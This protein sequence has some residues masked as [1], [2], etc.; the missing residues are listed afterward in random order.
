MLKAEQLALIQ[1][2]NKQ[3][4]NIRNT[5]LTYFR[6][7]FLS[8]GVVTGG[9]ICGFSS[10]VLSQI[11][12]KTVDVSEG[13]KWLYWVTV[14]LIMCF[15]F[16]NLLCTTFANMY[17]SEL[18]LRGPSGSMVRAVDGMVKEKD[19]I[20]LTLL[21]T[22]MLYQFLAL[23]CSFMVMDDYC[24]YVSTVI[25]VLGSYYWYTYCLRIYNRFKIHG[26]QFAWKEQVDGPRVSQRNPQSDGASRPSTINPLNKSG[27]KDISGDG[28][29]VTLQYRKSDDLSENNM[30]G[31]LDLKGTKKVL[32]RTVN[33]LDRKYFV[34]QGADLY[35]YH[36]KEEYELD[37]SKSVRSRP[38]SLAGYDVM[39]STDESGG[40]SIILTPDEDDA[41]MRSWEFCCDTAEQVQS[42]GEAFS[43]ASKTL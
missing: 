18:A 42:W 24:A 20:F 7:M 1:E 39:S 11:M 32:F 26:V 35:Y 12:A 14:P 30:Q 33:V 43:R 36:T 9:V 28:D 40:F 15:G 22:V 2:A 10:T 17:G 27:N 4:L 41:E 29:V 19:S 31:Y 8:F 34:V 23:C 13:W 21:V 37:P 5:E 38:I 6:D 3:L 25:L 16:H